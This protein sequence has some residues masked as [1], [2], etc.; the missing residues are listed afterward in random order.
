MA[1]CEITELEKKI[2]RILEIIRD[3]EPAA[4]VSPEFKYHKINRFEQ[5]KVYVDLYIEV[6]TEH[7]HQEYTEA[8]GTFDDLGMTGEFVI[9]E[10]SLSD[11]KDSSIFIPKEWLEL[12]LIESWDELKDLAINFAKRHAHKEKIEKL[13][14][15]LSSLEKKQNIVRSKLE[16]AKKS[17][18]ENG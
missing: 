7:G 11:I 15:E 4:L 1:F 17:K 2:R 5:D 14:K 16:Q 18:E 3:H 6:E 10:Y 12:A 8:T 13:R 9:D